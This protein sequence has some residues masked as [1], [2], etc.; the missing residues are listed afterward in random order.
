MKKVE[1]LQYG[2]IFKKAFC[3][4]EIFRAFVKDFSGKPVSVCC[5]GS[6]TTDN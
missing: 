1:S 2:V 3:V 4:P 5:S 6:L